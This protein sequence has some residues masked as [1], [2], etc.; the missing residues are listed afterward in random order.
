M[1]THIIV[2]LALRIKHPGRYFIKQNTVLFNIVQIGVYVSRY[3]KISYPKLAKRK[4]LEPLPIQ[5]FFKIGGPDGARTHDP[6]TASQILSQLSYR[7]VLINMLITFYNVN[8]LLASPNVILTH[9]QHSVKK[10][11]KRLFMS[12][13]RYP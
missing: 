5:A 6:L 9:K 4:R 3:Q 2:L 11:Y 12:S 1:D 10:N 13:N 8:A 7:P